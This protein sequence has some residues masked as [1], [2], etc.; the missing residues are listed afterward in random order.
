MLPA[1]RFGA[2][3]Q[4]GDG[5]AALSWITL[6]DV[7][8]AIAFLVARRLDGPVN[9]TTPEPTTQGELA[10]ALGRALHRPVL[11]R[12]PGALLRLAV[13]EMADSVLAGARILPKRLIEAGFPFAHPTLPGALDHAL[14]VHSAPDARNTRINDGGDRLHQ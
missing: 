8:A 1:F 10:T 9:L 7:V 6:D 14:A 13:G 12:L 3:A 4:L 11:F 2:G 5:K